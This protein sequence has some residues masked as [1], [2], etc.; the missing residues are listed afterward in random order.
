M[1][2]SKQSSLDELHK[3]S[4]ECIDNAYR[5]GFDDG[6][7][8]Q[9]ERH[10][11]TQ[12]TAVTANAESTEECQLTNKKV[13]D[14]LAAANAQETKEEWGKLQYDRGLEDGYQG[15]RYLNEWFCSTSFY[16]DE[17]DLFPEYKRRQADTCCL[18]DIITDVGFAEVLKRV[19][20]YEEKKKAEEEI[21]IGDEVEVDNTYK[22]IVTRICLIDDKEY[23]CVLFHDGSA[24]NRKIES[25]K[26]TGKHFDEV[27]KLL[28]D[29]QQ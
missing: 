25:L 4:N 20:A 2:Q 3:Q 11:K 18:E 12:L 17:S 29:T 24:G 1:G 22:A 21:K 8:A 27:A 19:K 9:E 23:A 10:Q 16:R 14:L 5:R 6:R 7:I 13:Y 26:K 15:Y 28:D